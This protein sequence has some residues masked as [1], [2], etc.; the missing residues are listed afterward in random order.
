MKSLGQLTDFRQP[1]GFLGLTGFRAR[2][3]HTT[4]AAVFSVRHS[5]DGLKHMTTCRRWWWESPGMAL[6]KKSSAE[7]LSQR[8]RSSHVARKGRFSLPSCKRVWFHWWR[9]CPQ[10]GTDLKFAECARRWWYMYAYT[11]IY[12]YICI[13]VYVCMYLYLSIY[14]FDGWLWWFNTPE[15]YK[16]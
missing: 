4:V 6:T 8:R 10:P 1:D 12:I 2:G 9:H 11:Y 16:L 3:K 14:S 15:T 5:A 7:G 13:Y